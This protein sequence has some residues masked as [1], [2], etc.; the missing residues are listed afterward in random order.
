MNTVLAQLHRHRFLWLALLLVNSQLIT[1]WMRQPFFTPDGNYGYYLLSLRH[2]ITPRAVVG[3]AYELLREH[4]LSWKGFSLLQAA[5]AFLAYNLATAGAYRLLRQVPDR[6]FAG[7][8]AAFIFSLPSTF[9][10]ANIRTAF[11]I[12]LSSMTL[13]AIPMLPHLWLLPGVM[14]I[15]AIALFTHENML[16]MY[17]PLLLGIIVWKDGFRSFRPWLKISAIL[18]TTAVAF[19]AICWHRQKIST[20]G[21][22][23]QRLEQHLQSLPVEPPPPSSSVV[24]T[25]HMTYPEHIRSVWEHFFREQ[26]SPQQLAVNILSLLIMAPAAIILFRLWRQVLGQV[27]DDPERRRRLLLLLASCFGAGALF[28]IAHDYI[29]WVSA[30]FICHLIALLVVLADRTAGVDL[31]LTRR[32][33]W[34]MAVITA[35]YLTVAPPSGIAIPTA[36][37]LAYPIHKL[38]L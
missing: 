25:F 15:V 14:A 11:D 37:F 8:L 27:R 3:T 30:L 18:L 17:V 21:E 2:A 35:F 29:R 16:F 9:H 20:D 13:L 22:A 4:G 7:L 19:G 34:V 6:R 12:Y 24:P 31:R 33:I 23:A 1:V 36:D 38:C 32:Q 5:Y 28:F 10:H 26:F